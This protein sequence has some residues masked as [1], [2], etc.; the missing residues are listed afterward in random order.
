MR[1]IVTVSLVALL[2]AGCGPRGKKSG[3]VSGKVTY[4]GQP[5]NGAALLLY[6]SAGG[7]TAITVGVNQAGEFHIVD[8][9]PGEYKI[10]VRGTAGAQQVDPRLLKKMSPEKRAEAEAKLKDM[11]TPP[12]IK[13]PDKYKDPKTTDLKVTITDKDQSMN[14]DLQGPAGAGARKES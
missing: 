9:P 3:T 1:R 14:L 13:F 6:P 11:N 7:D 4:Q 10:V 8:V 2:L 5:V 12:T